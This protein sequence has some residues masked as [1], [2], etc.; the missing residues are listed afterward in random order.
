MEDS[1]M[2]A[3]VRAEEIYLHLN[4]SSVLDGFLK[5]KMLNAEAF[6]NSSAKLK[7]EADQFILN[8]SKSANMNAEK[9]SAIDAEV[10]ADGN[11]KTSIN[12]S[13]KLKLT[14]KDKSEVSVYNT[15][16]IDLV[17]FS[18]KAALIKKS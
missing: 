3:E 14:A 16:E 6:E 7:G 18:E 15:P 4:G 17:E 1:K 8:V 11:S 13:K 10:F 5:S 9:L 2:N 12:V